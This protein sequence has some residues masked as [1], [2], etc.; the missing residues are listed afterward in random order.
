LCRE[1]N[2]KLVHGRVRHPQSQGQVEHFNQ[3]L[4]RGLAK[5]IQGGGEDPKNASWLK[6]LGQAVYNYNIAVH[7][8]SEKIFL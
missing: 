3:T 4:T 8:A 6:F 2:V 5:H 1:F 7:F